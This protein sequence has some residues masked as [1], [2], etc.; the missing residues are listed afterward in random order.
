MQAP[1]TPSTFKVTVKRARADASSAPARTTSPS[2]SNTLQGSCVRKERMLAKLSK[3]RTRA[4]TRRSQFAHAADCSQC[5]RLA[6]TMSDGRVGRECTDACYLAPCSTKLAK[7]DLYEQ[8]A[9]DGNAHPREATNIRQRLKPLR[10]HTKCDSHLHLQHTEGNT[11]TNCI[12]NRHGRI[13]VETE[14]SMLSTHRNIT[15]EQK[16]HTARQLHAEGGHDGGHAETRAHTIESQIA[17]SADCPCD[18]QRLRRMY[19]QRRRQ[20]L[21]ETCNLSLVRNMQQ[22]TK[23]TLTNRTR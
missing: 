10:I 20:E 23:L 4:H 12:C 2:K 9:C 8:V 11:G 16:Q 6:R 13:Q 1:R 5:Q 3:Q 7:A 22:H 21:K 15:S 17:S 18:C 14:T 19:E